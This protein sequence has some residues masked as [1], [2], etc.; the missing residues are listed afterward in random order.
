MAHIEFDTPEE[1]SETDYL[2]RSLS[3]WKGKVVDA[4]I[5]Y[6]CDHFEPITLDLHT[7]CSIGHFSC[8]EQCL[9]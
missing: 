3:V 6:Y 4:D 8:V 1:A 5:S 7:A 2:D 9:K